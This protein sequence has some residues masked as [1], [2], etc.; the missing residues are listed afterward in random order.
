[1]T[2]KRIMKKG[3]RSKSTIIVV[4][5]NTTVVTDVGVATIKSTVH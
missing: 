4:N 5:D 1:M 3:E 2:M